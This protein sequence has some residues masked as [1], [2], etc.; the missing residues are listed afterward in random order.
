MLILESGIARVSAPISSLANGRSEHKVPEHEPAEEYTKRV[1]SLWK[2]GAHV[3][4][5]GGV[6]N[7]IHNAAVIG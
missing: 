5:A 3:S 6:E 4:T 2:I 1:T 7:A